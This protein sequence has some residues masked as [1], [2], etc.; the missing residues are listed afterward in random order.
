MSGKQAK[1]LRRELKYSTQGHKDLALLVSETSQAGERDKARVLATGLIINRRIYQHAK[2]LMRGK[3]PE[4]RAKVVAA[5][6]AHL[7][8]VEPDE[9]VHGANAGVQSPIAVSTTPITPESIEQM[10]AAVQKATPEIPAEVQEQAAR[11][12]P[13]AMV[14][15]QWIGD[16]GATAKMPQ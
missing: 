15:R 14:G 2:A 8:N 13:V 4:E 12:E 5:F 10:Q 6:T 1:R 7:K 9:R 11:G 16:G 3:S